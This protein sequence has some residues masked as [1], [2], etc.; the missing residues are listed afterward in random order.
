MSI[1]LCQITHRSLMKVSRDH[2]A[3]SRQLNNQLHQPLHQVYSLDSLVQLTSSLSLCE[4]GTGP[5]YAR[6]VGLL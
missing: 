4:L 1:I 2:F 6:S 3:C 5:C